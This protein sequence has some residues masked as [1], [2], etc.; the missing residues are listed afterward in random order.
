MAKD[1]IIP[2][3]KNVEVTCTTCK[4]NRVTS[5]PA[6]NHFLCEVCRARIFQLS[7]LLSAVMSED[8]DCARSVAQ[9]ILNLEL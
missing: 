1:N 3:L 9:S 7:D 2:I 5:F 6:P 8:F 4:Q